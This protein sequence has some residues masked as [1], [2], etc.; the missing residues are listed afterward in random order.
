[1]PS[2]DVVST[3]DMQEIKNAVEQTKKEITTR[4]DFKDSKSTVELKEKELELILVADDKMRMSAMNE[5]MK[6]RLSKRNVSLKSLEIKDPEPAGGDTFRQ[7]IKVKQ[8]LTQD[9]LKK[10]NKLIKDKKLKVTSQ[11]QGDQLRITGKQRDDLQTVIA[12]LKADVQDLSLQFIN[13]RD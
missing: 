7:V 13:F 10:I 9:E 11:I 4:Y 3:V 5:I 2:F 6:Q 8:G 1:M 12:A